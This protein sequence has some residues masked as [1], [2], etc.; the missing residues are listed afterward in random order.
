MSHVL[1]SE[2]AAQSTSWKNAFSSQVL[3]TLSQK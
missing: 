1:F 2:V 3:E